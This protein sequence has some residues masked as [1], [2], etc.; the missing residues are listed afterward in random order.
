MVLIEHTA[1]IRNAH[2]ILIAKR[3]RETAIFFLRHMS[4]LEQGCPNAGR[5]VA[6]ATKFL[7]GNA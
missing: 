7:Y 5:Q 3:L 6:P 2:K 4:S 1:E